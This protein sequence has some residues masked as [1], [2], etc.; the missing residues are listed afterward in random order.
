MQGC[1]KSIGGVLFAIV[2]AALLLL[3]PHRAAAQTYTFRFTDQVTKAPLSGVTIYGNNGVNRAVSRFSDSRG[4]WSLD[5]ASV[6]PNPVVTFSHLAGG[7]RFIPSEITVNLTNCPGFTCSV[8]AVADGNP[9]AVV[10]GRVTTSRGAAVPGVSVYMPGALVPGPK[11]SDS[12]GYTLFAAPKAETACNDADSDLNN[13]FLSILPVAEGNQDC[14][15][16]IRAPQRLCT[17]GGNVSGSIQASCGT[18]AQLPIG[19]STN[20]QIAVRTLSGAAVPGVLFYGNN[21]INDL[22]PAAR[23]TNS[24]GR[25]SVSTSS[26]GAQASDVIQLVPTGGYQFVP[27]ALTLSPNSCANNSCPIWAIP[28]VSTQGVVQWGARENGAAKPGVAILA[29]QLYSLEPYRQ[30]TDRSGAAFFPAILRTSGCNDT[31]RSR[32][33]DSLTLNASFSGCSFSHDS[34]TPF[35]S[36]PEKEVTQGSFEA[37]CDGGVTAYHTV[38]GTVFDEN[39]FPSRGAQIALDNSQSAITAEDGSYSL[40]VTEGRTFTVTARDG[41]KKFDPEQIS[42]AEISGNHT[43]IDFQAQLPLPV[44][45]TDLPDEGNCPVQDSYAVSGTVLDLW[46][47]PLGG[48]EILNNHE[49]VTTSG[50]DG[51]YSFNVTAATDNWV[52]AEYQDHNFDPAGIA[53]PDTRCDKPD[54]NFKV[55]PYESY[56]LSGTIKDSTGNPIQ[57]VIVRLTYDDTRYETYTNLDGIY[58]VSVPEEKKYQLEPVLVGRDFTPQLYSGV[59]YRSEDAIDFVAAPLPT[60]TP[61]PTATPSNT[62]TPGNTPTPT[63]TPTITATPTNTATPTITP[64]STATATST[65]TP[66][67]TP[68]ST[69]TPTPTIT[70]TSTRTPL[71]TATSRPTLTPTPTSTPRNTATPTVTATPTITQTPTRTPTPEPTATATAT[72]TVTPTPTRTSTP[73]VTPTSTNTPTPTITPTPTATAL[74]GVAL[75]GVCFDKPSKTLRWEVKANPG[76]VVRWDIYGSN[77]SGKI[78]IATEG[79]STFESIWIDAN[80]NIARVFIGE[81]QVAN[82][83]PSLGECPLPPTPEPTATP[84]NTATPSP[85]PSS[86]P[87]PAPTAP[88]SGSEP[89]TGTPEPSPPGQTPQPAPNQ[90]GTDPSP[91]PTATPAPEPTAEPTRVISGRIL[92]R[93]GRPLPAAQRDLFAEL[94]LEIKATNLKTR[95][96]ST[97]TMSSML[98]WEAALP[99]GRYRVRLFD[100]T[101]K[102]TVISRPQTYT[103]NLGERDRRGFD[104]AIRFRSDVSSPTGGQARNS[105]RSR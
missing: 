32:A 29:P 96:Q 54:I 51:R 73:T 60:P 13:N 28:N 33:D 63:A 4:I 81:H 43:G 99:K 1:I 65:A 100:P 55:V 50:K 27:A 77:Q 76:L 56:I 89:P 83:S 68:T 75:S 5:I 97:A 35:R 3:T 62:P 105:G 101:S 6:S 38:S 45:S 93:N 39:G 59:A 10:E 31:N 30:F 53:L 41:V 52:T 95:S 34:G 36:C 2:S 11:R 40:V 9:S 87:A 48:V 19:S 57:D 104:F 78:E 66:T 22:R 16:S 23:T 91:E 26:I 85:D 72:P 82:A 80:P 67:V 103:V 74:P 42:F 90:P 102:V 15:F 98:G 47:N 46:G 17:S 86:T 21:G 20:Y 70:P 24:L 12:S 44:A 7:Y 49:V 69:I 14:T 79:L 61:T 37:R 8:S 18:A 25:L 71:P 94:G 92:G 58:L 88:P 64:T 84:E